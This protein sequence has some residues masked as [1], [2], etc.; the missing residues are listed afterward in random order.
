MQCF[1]SRLCFTPVCSLSLTSTLVQCLC[2]SVLVDY[3]S[4]TLLP[5]DLVSFNKAAAC[6]V[7]KE[8]KLQKENK[9]VEG[10]RVREVKCAEQTC[11]GFKSLEG[12]FFTGEQLLTIFWNGLCTLS[13]LVGGSDC[14][15]S[16]TMYEGVGKVGKW[17]KVWLFLQ[18][19]VLSFYWG[20]AGLN[21]HRLSME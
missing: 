11:E 7:D 5:L 3:L 14:L 21:I 17:R 13:R 12:L 9:W 15:L 16:Y 10:W 2:V 6:T 4:F 8:V 18:T 19:L 20:G 1:P